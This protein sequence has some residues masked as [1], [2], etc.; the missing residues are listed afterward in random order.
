[1]K[2]AIVGFG[3]RGL[4]S[5][6]C[7]VEEAV[8]TARLSDIKIVICDGNSDLGTGLAWR[9]D[10]TDSNWINISDRALQ[11]LEGRKAINSESVSIPAFKSYIAWLKEYDPAYQPNSN[12]DSFPPRKIMGNYLNARAKSIVEPLLKSGILQLIDQAVTNVLWTQKRFKLCLKNNAKIECDICLLTIGHTPTELRDEAKENIRHAKN[13][14][15]LYINDP[16]KEEVI[17]KN[18]KNKNVAIIG[19]GLSMLDIMRMLT[20]GQGGKFLAKENN[21]MQFI[22]SDKVPDKIIPYSFDGLPC[23]PKPVGEK[24]DAL[25]EPSEAQITSFKTELREKINSL[26]DNFTPK[27]LIQ[28]FSNYAEKIYLENID[29]ECNLSLSSLIANYI[30]DEDDNHAVFLDTSLP[31]EEY[32]NR[33]IKMALGEIKPSL[34]FFLGQVW[35]HFQPAMYRVFAFPDISAESVKEIIAIDERLKRYSYGPPVSS[36]QQM[37]ALIDCG[38]ISTHFLNDPTIEQIESG[39]QFKLEGNESCAEVLINS[40]MDNPELSKIDSPLLKSLKEQ[41][42]VK[43]VTDGLGIK[44]NRFAKA[45]NE[46]ED[47]PL[48][49]IGRNAKGSILGA[50]AILECFS[51]DVRTWA[52]HIVRPQ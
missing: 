16:Y 28:V 2:V 43:E 31:F 41:N 50:D 26:K 7:L 33:S 52:K 15:L 38:I 36:M 9:L 40:V 25:F 51:T 27:H 35:R 23:M 44:T 3:P 24:V 4:Y 45:I 48:Y 32:V 6:E 14:S 34:D 46:F 13:C 18:Y 8:A 1:M 5:L 11:N 20:V 22:A 10:Q 37:V 19:L 39:W 29:A 17:S 30:L 12:R 47:V 49:I 21:T 42:L